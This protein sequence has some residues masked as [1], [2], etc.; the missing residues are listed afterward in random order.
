MVS[1]GTGTTVLSSDGAP[2]T[3]SSQC[4]MALVGPS[5]RPSAPEPTAS[6]ISGTVITSGD[7]C[8]CTSSV[9]RRLPWKVMRN[10]RVM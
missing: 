1:T 5:T 7:S 9:Q 4:C 6:T 10:S 3:G 8:G 2:T